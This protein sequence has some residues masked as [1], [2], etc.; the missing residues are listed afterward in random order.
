MICNVNLPWHRLRPQPRLKRCQSQEAWFRV[1]LA[2]V[3]FVCFCGQLYAFRCYLRVGGL[4]ATKRHKIHKR[5]YGISSVGTRR[6]NRCGQCVVSLR[7]KK[8][9]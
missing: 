5:N 4:L 3:S 7:V 8:E 2:F 6:A 9:N 1:V